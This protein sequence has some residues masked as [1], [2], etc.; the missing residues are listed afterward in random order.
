MRSDALRRPVVV[1]DLDNT[2][3]DESLYLQAADAAIARRLAADG[4]ASEEAVARTLK[5]ERRRGGRGRLFDRVIAKLDLEPATMKTMLE[6][7][8]TV[9]VPGGLP[10]RPWV[11]RCFE[12]LR[13]AGSRLFVF[14]N[15]N[16]VQ[17]RNKVRLLNLDLEIVYAA[18]TAPKPAP[19]GLLHIGRISGQQPAAMVFIGNDDLDRAAA[20]AAGCAYVDVGEVEAMFRN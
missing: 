14:T 13:G 10:L 1:F 11:R 12:D 2:L 8:R 7:L 19:D 18:E 4:V 16:A 3:Y 15:G 17:Q 9:D 20:S 5:E 6:V